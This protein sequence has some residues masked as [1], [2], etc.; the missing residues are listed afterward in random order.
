MVSTR[1]RALL[2][3]TRSLLAAILLLVTLTSCGSNEYL[4]GRELFERSCAPCHS[5]DGTG[6]FGPNIG[7]GSNAATNLS[8]E[9]VAGVIRVGPGSMPG[10]GR[11]SD[12]QIASLVEYVRDLERP[13]AD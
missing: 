10:F 1:A 6:G 11:L 13:A 2:A 5:A 8:D 7:P 9:Q 4:L 12:E 3:A